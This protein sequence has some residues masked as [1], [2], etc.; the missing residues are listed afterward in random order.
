MIFCGGWT[1]IIHD[2]NTTLTYLSHFGNT[3]NIAS[4]FYSDST[5]GIGWGTNDNI[6]KMLSININYSELK[7]Q[8]SGSYNNPSG[9]LGLLVLSDIN[10]SF[11][12][13]NDSWGDDLTGQSL[14]INNIAIL[15]QSKTNVFNRI[16]TF[17]VANKTQLN[18]SMY[19]YINTFPYTK[20]YIYN[21]KV[22]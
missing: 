15:N 14:N 7:I 8:Y 3:S 20:R 11:F 5:Y 1:E 12:V 9:G 19:G 4:T 13:F 16:D 21:L 18:V 17:I 10:N 6:Q 22:R 2:A